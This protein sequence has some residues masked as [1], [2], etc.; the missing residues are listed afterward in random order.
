MNLADELARSN[1]PAS[2]QAAILAQLEQQASALAQHEAELQQR[3]QK[4]E[5]LT[6]ELA[7]WR[8][9]RFGVKSE[10]LAAEQRD[11]F[12]DTLDSDIA[13]LEA[14]LAELHTAAAATP[15]Q[16][17]SAT[18]RARAG[19]QPLPAHLP[20]LEITHEPAT[21][22]CAACQSSLVKIGEDVSEQLDYQPGSFRVLR[23]HRPQYACQHCETVTAAPVAPAIIDGGLPTPALLAWVMV[24]KYTDHLPLYRLS[25]IAERSG[26]EL[27]RST[28]ASWVGVVGVWLQPLADRLA[29]QLRQQTILHADET[30]VQQ[31]DPGSGK[32]KRAYLWAYRSNDLAGGPPIIV[33]DYQTSRSGKHAHAFLLDWRGQLMVDDYAGYK[34]LFGNGVSEL[35]CWAHARRKFHDYHQA[36]GSPVAAEA[37]QRIAALYAVEG[38]AGRL[39]PAERQT[40]RQQQSQPLLTEFKHW[41]DEQLQHAAPNSGLAKALSYSARRWVALSGYADSGDAPIDNNPVE[42]AIRPIALGKKNWLFAGSEASGRRAAAIQSLL[43]TAKLNGIEPLS[44]LT[45]T[46]EKLPAWPNSQID[47]LL[48][49]RR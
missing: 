10:A 12:H 32:T 36:T 46:L 22:Q 48:P 18:P 30:P 3:D 23:H 44:W 5:A 19:R 17:T 1:L 37:L 4:I 49:L 24:S 40:V 16:Q 2:V 15:V 33:F 14:R 28:L 42:N 43:G 26:V 27:A 20:R 45:E 39:T 6:L 8:R 29:G 11:L 31:L 7:H 38:A 41:L 47:E 13:A 25:Q 35:A 9:L 21:C 34:A